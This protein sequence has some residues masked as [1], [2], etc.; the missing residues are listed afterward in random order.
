[1]NVYKILYLFRLFILTILF[2]WV[3]FF[4]WIN[5]ILFDFVRIYDSVDSGFSVT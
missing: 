1:M 4:E 5:D 2:V 3:K